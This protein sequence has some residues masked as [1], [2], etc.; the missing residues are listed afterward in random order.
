MENGIAMIWIVSAL[1]AGGTLLGVR[2]VML[3]AIP[4][5]AADRARAARVMEEIR[6]R[7]A[8]ARL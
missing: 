4:D 2:Q 6:R 7:E 1:V 8:A 5:R 3:S